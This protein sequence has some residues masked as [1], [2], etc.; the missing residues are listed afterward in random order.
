MKSGFKWAC[1]YGRLD[2]V[3]YLLD[4][5]V[6]VTERHRGETSLHVA[7]YGGHVEAVALLLQR[8]A[9]VEAEDEVWANTPLGWALYAW[10]TLSPDAKPD[11]YY[12]V[13]ARLVA[14]GATVRPEWLDDDAISND[15]RMLAA[16]DRG[17]PR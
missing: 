14:A 16:L 6:D 11:P 3:R 4:T 1:A 2:V 13:V 17:L 10:S 7:A 5:G 15:R 8:G 12:D 9:P